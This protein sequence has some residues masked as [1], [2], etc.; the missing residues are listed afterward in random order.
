MDGLFLGGLVALGLTAVG[1][2]ILAIFLQSRLNRMRT[3]L[4]TAE[5]RAADFERERERSPVGLLT[6]QSD[7]QAFVGTPSL[8]L[9]HML[10]LSEGPLDVDTLAAQFEAGGAARLA[11]I[12]ADPNRARQTGGLT[13]GP[14]VFGQWF[15]VY[16]QPPGNDDEHAA[17][18]W[19][20]EITSEVE[21]YQQAQRTLERLD[22][23]F[24]ALPVP[25]WFRNANLDVS[26]ANSAYAHAVGASRDAV[27]RGH[28]EFL[29]NT[30]QRDGVAL[31][32]KARDRGALATARHHVVVQGSRRL[33]EL[34]ELPIGDD[35][36]LGL[37]IDR[38]QEEELEGKLNRHINANADVLESLNTAIVIFGADLRVRFYNGAYADL[39]GMDAVFLDSEPHVTEI[40]DVLRDR[41]ALPEQS[42]FPA[43]KRD[44]VEKLRDLV[45]PEEELIH[46]PDERTFKLTRTPHPFGGVLVTYEDVTD[47]LT[48]ERNFNTLIDV[49]RETIENLYEAVAVFGPDGRLKLY[50]HAFVGLWDLSETAVEDQ[51]HIRE[52]INAAR[53]RFPVKDGKWDWLQERIVARAT[54][55]EFRRGRM[56]LA[57]SAVIDWAQ[58]PLP[59]GQSLFTYFDV[60]DS[61]R[62]E[63]ALRERA[64]ALETADQLK[65]EFIANISYELRTPLNAI[66]GF[67]EILENEF[68]GTLNERQKEYALSI[69]S[70]SQ[71]L[72]TLIN[73]ILD[74]AT[75][76]AGYMELERETLKMGDML[77]SVRALAFERARQRG[78]TL[79]I[80]C[81]DP[82]VEFTADPRRIRQAV[83]NVM[84]N[85]FN[86]TPEGG[87]VTLRGERVGDEV[88][89]SV[90]DTGVGIPEQEQERVF[91]KFE[92]GDTRSGGAGL[93]LSL[94][95]SLVQLHG[96][97]V[98]LQSEPN[99]GTRATCALPITP[100]VTDSEPEA[101]LV[102]NSSSDAA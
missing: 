3:E 23:V 85:A 81:P 57:D 10:D 75:I 83:Y 73:D 41:R 78:L 38:T 60:T 18:L 7:K 32:E 58:V 70:S 100:S 74:L 37:A 28:I 45:Q 54:E 69:T 77:N 29:G 42:N 87:R 19:F 53:R 63:R 90:T 89:I 31:A 71:R 62:V 72:T 98:M 2:W 36:T 76:E 56:E 22:G 27:R 17:R 11:D 68:H 55:P 61:I 39:W 25:V 80:E 66:V 93:G 95:R 43:Y 6:L 99:R 46:R 14:T 96:G 79:E 5:R 33:M 30:L 34:E 102:A 82:N 47:R 65:S 15:A 92:R 9:R 64:E 1:G 97:R 48:L 91:L 40:L 49:Q 12:C 51:P 52:I 16:A 20:A 88:H 67:A 26:D 21:A 101:S 4:R 8:R 84:S 35:K 86:Y 24:D 94:V 44:T 50:N 59:D 13:V